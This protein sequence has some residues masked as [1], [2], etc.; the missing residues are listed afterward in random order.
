[1]LTRM[2][3]SNRAQEAL[4]AGLVELR[5]NRS[6]M[7]QR[8]TF[9]TKTARLGSIEYNELFTERTIELTELAKIANEIGLPVEA[10]NGHA[11][12]E[13]TSA[14]DFKTASTS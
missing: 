8:I 1:M 11:F 14:S 7:F 12:P 3:L 2:R 10:P 4:K 9:R 6:G 13:G 5:V